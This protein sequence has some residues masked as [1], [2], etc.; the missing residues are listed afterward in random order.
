MPLRAGVTRMRRG[1]P[2]PSSRCRG[3]LNTQWAAVTTTFGDDQ[4]SG[5]AGQPAVAEVALD[6]AH[7]GIRTV[8]DVRSTR[9]RPS[10]GPT[11]A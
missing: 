4:K 8:V 3:R 2:R 10:V 6:L 11:M 7:G 1:A 5:A 9:V